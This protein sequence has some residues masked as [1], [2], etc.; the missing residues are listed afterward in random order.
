MLY[1]LK[2]TAI[3][4]FHEFNL[5]LYRVC[6]NIIAAIDNLSGRESCCNTPFLSQ[7][8]IGVLA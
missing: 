3:F 6:P 7:E 1:L 4:L 8:A 5:Q 2:Q